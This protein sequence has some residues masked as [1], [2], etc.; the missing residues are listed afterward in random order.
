MNQTE[1]DVL[2]FVEEND[3]KFIKL[4]FCDKSGFMKNISIMP[5]E[6]SKAFNEGVMI[7]GHYIYNGDLEYENFELYLYPD[8]STLHILPWRPQEGRVMR[9]FCYIKDREGNSFTE[10]YRHILK[11][12][13][14]KLEDLGYDLKVGF[15]C[16][17]YLFN[18]THEKPID[19][20]SYLDVAPFDKGENIR[21]EICLF[22]EMMG[23]YPQNSHHEIG[24]G[25]NEIDFEC[26]SE[27]AGDNFLIFKNLVEIIALRNGYVADL[28]STPLEDCSKNIY[29]LKVELKRVND[30]MPVGNINIYNEEIEKWCKQSLAGLLNI[31]DILISKNNVKVMACDY[32]INPY[33]VM[34][35][36]VDLIES[37]VN[38]KFGNFKK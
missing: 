16:P 2:A 3:V 6:L 5:K 36:L 4:A 12:K 29:S 1:K 22:M 35:V 31:Y 13:I 32:N 26:D 21:R 23:I 37:I 33:I 11:E 25:Q 38:N 20:A 7:K 18:S 8:A 17:F 27:Y 34:S 9:L 24:P 15:E 28:S 19:N 30:D 10:D 14:S